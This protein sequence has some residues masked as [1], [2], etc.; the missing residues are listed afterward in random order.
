MS[1]EA[2]Q[3][4]IMWG[5]Q[6][7]ITVGDEDYSMQKFGIN[8]LRNIVSSYCNGGSN[9]VDEWRLYYVFWN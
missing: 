1:F 9:S 7:G 4:Y 5:L 8:M 2:E 6:H 3:P